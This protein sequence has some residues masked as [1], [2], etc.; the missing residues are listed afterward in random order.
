MY[1]YQPFTP[2]KCPKELKPSTDAAFGF[3]PNDQMEPSH[4][5]A[6]QA[7]KGLQQVC[8]LWKVVLKG[9]TLTPIALCLVW[10]KEAVAPGKG[11]IAI[12]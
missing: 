11:E 9:V 6:V 2:G 4:L 8:I 3:V 5:Q 1:A 7:A 12:K 10:V